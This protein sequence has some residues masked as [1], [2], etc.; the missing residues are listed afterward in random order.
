M[1]SVLIVIPLNCKILIVTCCCVYEVVRQNKFFSGALTVVKLFGPA[2]TRLNTTIVY[3]LFNER[4]KLLC[5][6][7]EIMEAK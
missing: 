2:N 5:T 7:H 3:F 6:E 4:Y 1:T